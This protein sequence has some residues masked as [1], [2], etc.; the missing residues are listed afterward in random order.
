MSRQSTGISASAPPSFE[1]TDLCKSFDGE[2]MVNDSIS[3]R[4]EPGEVFGL[5]G[6]NGAG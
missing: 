2:T 5:L 4:V 1:V 3:L 6:P